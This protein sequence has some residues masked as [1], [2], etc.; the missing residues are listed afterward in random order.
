[1]AEDRLEQIKRIWG[2]AAANSDIRWMIAEIERLRETVAIMS[3]KDTMDAIAEGQEDK[4]DPMRGYHSN[5][6]KGCILR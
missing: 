1:M 2:S 5:P 6:H 3:D 4:C